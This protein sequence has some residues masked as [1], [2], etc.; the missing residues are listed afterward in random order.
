M[1]TNCDLQIAIA[2][3]INEQMILIVI[4]VCLNEL[5]KVTTYFESK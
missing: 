3:E 1:L 5:F 4:D 2:T